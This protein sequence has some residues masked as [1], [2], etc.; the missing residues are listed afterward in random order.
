MVAATTA[1]TANRANASSSSS[2]DLSDR[3]LHMV[4]HLQF[5]WWLGHV[6]VVV[7]TIVYYLGYFT[8][9]YTMSVPAYSYALLGA[10]ASYAVATYKSM[11]KFQPTLQFASRLIISNDS[12]QYLILA[13][14]W[15]FQPPLV[16]TLV[17]FAV[18]SA[19]HT[20]TYFHG[21]VIPVLFPTAETLPNDSKPWLARLSA[22][23]NT[24]ARQYYTNAMHFVAR[25]EVT[26]ILVWTIPQVF[27]LQVSFYTPVIYM[28]FLR[29]RYVHSSCH[30]EAFHHLRRM[31]DQQ[32]VNNP[33]ANT[34]IRRLYVSTRDFIS[35][36]AGPLPRP[37]PAGR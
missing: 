4:T 29:N 1:G 30:Q 12:M 33:N 18:F 35:N 31:M 3:L 23:A 17:P 20:L 27:L 8:S 37:H 24:M 14:N 13:V 28:Q 6:T 36:L 26:V 10:I 9:Y 5:A 15:Y 16:V 11:G 21:T 7:C 2:S 22:S 19:L 34:G 25:W 32:F